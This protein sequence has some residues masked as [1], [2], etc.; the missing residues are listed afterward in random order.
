M[1][2]DAPPRASGGKIAKADLRAHAA[3]P[4]GR[5]TSSDTRPVPTQGTGWD[6]SGRRSPHLVEEGDEGVD[7]AGRDVAGG[8]PGRERG[9]G[10][11]R[12]VG[13]VGT[14][15]AQARRQPEAA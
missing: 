3:D 4:H 15:V 10:D 14:D 11:G 5:L 6:R 2:V 13:A 9:R 1:I 8:L 12:E 7:A